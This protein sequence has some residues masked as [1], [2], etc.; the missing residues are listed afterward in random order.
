VRPG[1]IYTEI[2][3][4]V[5]DPDRVDRMKSLVPMQRGGSAEEV[6]QA[7]L[8]LCSPHASYTTGLLLDVAGGRGL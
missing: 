5:G 7:V 3:A 8:W 4:S 1:L 6:A 2:H